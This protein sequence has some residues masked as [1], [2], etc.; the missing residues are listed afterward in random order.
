M[1]LA[2]ADGIA[3]DRFGMSLF[4]SKTIREADRLASDVGEGILRELFLALMWPEWPLALSASER[5][6]DFAGL[7]R[8]QVMHGE[9]CEYGTE[10]NSLMAMAL[11]NFFS[12]ILLDRP[13]T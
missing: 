12:F 4:S 13:S 5:P 2:Q 11:L 9:D 7:N 10:E 6:A 1:F 8:H 3:W